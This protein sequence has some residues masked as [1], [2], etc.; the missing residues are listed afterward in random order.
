MITQ[1]Y[2]T[3]VLTLIKILLEGNINRYF[4]IF[5]P[6][7]VINQPTSKIANPKQY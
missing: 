5:N 4:F 1:Y 7:R 2:P 6:C 3:Q